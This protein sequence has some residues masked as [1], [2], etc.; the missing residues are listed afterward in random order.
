MAKRSETVTVTVIVCDD[1]G[2]K[3]DG[4]KDRAFHTMSLSTGE[5]WD[6][7]SECS[8]KRAKGLSRHSPD[9]VGQDDCG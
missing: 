1:C 2:W 8:D 4:I 6:L 5:S 7:C 3:G 9:R